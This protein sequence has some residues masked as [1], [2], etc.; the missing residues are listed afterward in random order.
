MSQSFDPGSIPAIV[1]AGGKSKPDL[2]AATGQSIRALV[3]VHGKTLLAHITDALQGAPTIGS[4]A[5]IGDVPTSDDYKRLPDQGDFVANVLAGVGAFPD[6]PYVLIATSDLPFITAESIETFTQGACKRAKETNGQVIYPIVPVAL[7]YERFP[8]VKRTALRV[9]EGVFTGGNLM[10]VSPGFL[11]AQRELIADAYAARKSPLQLGMMLGTGVI[12]RLALS[13]KVSPGLLT[14]DYLE[15]RVS[16]LLRG[17]ARAF[18][19]Q[20]PLIATD[21][22]RPEDFAAVGIETPAKENMH[23]R[24]E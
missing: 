5:V 23:E 16:G 22:D 21:L 19:S 2:E 14:L 3:E 24:K 9:R 11:L 1:L 13:Q 17:A 12:L 6:T 15:G 7:C 18:L 8:G 20:D 10:L 4:I